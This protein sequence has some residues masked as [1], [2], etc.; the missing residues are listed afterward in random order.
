MRAE[1]VERA[2]ELVLSMNETI[3]RL[4][5]ALERAGIIMRSLAEAFQNLVTELGSDEEE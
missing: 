1:Q 5:V 4:A 2:R 3:Q